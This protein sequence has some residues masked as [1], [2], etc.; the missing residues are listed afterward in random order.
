MNRYEGI[1]STF[2]SL[3]HLDLQEW[4]QPYREKKKTKTLQVKAGWIPS[5]S[6]KIYFVNWLHRWENHTSGGKV[7]SNLGELAASQRL[8][9]VSSSSNASWHFLRDQVH[10][11]CISEFRKK[12]PSL[13][14]VWMLQLP[15]QRCETSVG[16]AISF[17]AFFFPRDG[18]C[19]ILT[20]EQDEFCH[21]AKS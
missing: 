11:L 6:K 14:R 19:N 5:G 8:R 2:C 3:F 16:A 18:S 7:D 1:Y 12:L 21:C 17:L 9:K 20:P 15:T 4:K 13:S 10:K